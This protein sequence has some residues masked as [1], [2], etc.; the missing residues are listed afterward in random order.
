MSE[1]DVLLVAEPGF[2]PTQG[3]PGE[4]KRSAAGSG[5]FPGLVRVGR[6]GRVRGPRRRGRPGRPGVHGRAGSRRGR[7]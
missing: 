3:N 2:E 5:G 1:V 7:L 4:N 6:R